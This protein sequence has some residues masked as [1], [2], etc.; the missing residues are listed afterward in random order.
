MPAALVVSTAAAA[1]SVSALALQPLLA[2]TGRIRR[3]R[4]L[5]AI[6]LVLV[7]AHIGG[8]AL[9]SVEDTLFAMSP[10]GPTRARMALIAT[11]ALVLSVALGLA[12]RRLPFGPG[13]WRILH[14]YLAVVVIVLGFGH[15]ILT[16]GALDAAGTV[17][18]VAAGRRGA[19]PRRRGLRRPRPGLKRRRPPGGTRAAIG[20]NRAAHPRCPRRESAGCHEFWEYDDGLVLA[21]AVLVEQDDA[22]LLVRVRAGEHGG[23]RLVLAGV[24]REVRHAG[25]DEEEVA[26]ARTPG[27]PAAPRRSASPPAR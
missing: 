2:A 13:T 27:A 10:D 21:A 12:R 16:D 4:A 9:V 17:V 11:I 6:A 18:L 8:L 3:H 5:G 24:V 22:L 20:L 25:G 14:G 19:G 1:L 23:A 26:G 7:L 15:A